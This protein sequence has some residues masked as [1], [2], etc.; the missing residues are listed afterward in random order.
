MSGILDTFAEITGA[1]LTQQNFYFFFFTSNPCCQRF[2]AN[3]E[4]IPKTLYNDCFTHENL[5]NTTMLDGFKIY[6]THQNE[7]SISKNFFLKRVPLLQSKQ[8]QFHLFKNFI[9]LKDPPSKLI[10]PK[11]LNINELHAFCKPLIVEFQSNHGTIGCAKE[12]T[13]FIS[14][15]QLP[16]CSK[17]KKLSFRSQDCDS[18]LLYGFCRRPTVDEPP[19]TSYLPLGKEFSKETITGHSK[20]LSLATDFKELECPQKDACS[21]SK[22]CNSSNAENIKNLLSDSEYPSLPERLHLNVLMSWV[23]HIRTSILL[24][25]SLDIVLSFLIIN[26]VL[27]CMI[28]D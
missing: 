6:R 13:P 7:K 27:Y 20:I 18:A 16:N 26:L 24:H 23:D 4:V 28:M 22:V 15:T 1:T 19:E 17:H 10:S 11:L 14:F 9:K 12:K 25:I 5:L 8:E 3:C 21:I 2:N